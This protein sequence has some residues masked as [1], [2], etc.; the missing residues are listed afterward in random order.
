MDKVCKKFTMTRYGDDLFCLNDLV[1]NI[2]GSTNPELYMKKISKK[3]KIKDKYYVPEDR[4]MSIIRSSKSDE[5]IEAKELLEQKKDANK[6]NV[7]IFTNNK[8]SFNGKDILTL[9]INNDVW[10]K[11]GDLAEYLEY[12]DTRDA[13][14]LVHDKFKK[15]YKDIKETITKDLPNQNIPK[16]NIQD[17][18][19]FL[20][21]SGMYMLM[22]RSHKEIAVDFCI[23]V[24]EEVLPQIRKTGSYVQKNANGV[25]QDLFDNINDYMGFHCFYIICVGNGIYKLGQT[26]SITRRLREHINAYKDHYQGIIE[27]IKFEDYNDMMTIETKMKD[28]I[29][30]KN[31]KCSEKRLKELFTTTVSQCVL[32]SE[33]TFE[34][35][36]QFDLEFI[37]EKIIDYQKEL[38]VVDDIVMTDEEDDKTDVV[39]DETVNKQIN[40]FLREKHNVAKKIVHSDKDLE[41]K[42]MSHELE[43]KKIELEM[44]KLK[45]SQSN[46]SSDDE[47]NKPK[48]KSLKKYKMVEI[49]DESSESEVEVQLKKLK[50]EK[51]IDDERDELVKNNKTEQTDVTFFSAYY[52]EAGKRRC[53]GCNKFLKK[54]VFE[55]ETCKMQAKH[56]IVRLEKP[57]YEQL[58]KDMI[59]LKSKSKVAIK[60]GV[61]GPTI[62]KWIEEYEGV[63]VIAK[64]KKHKYKKRTSDSSKT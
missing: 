22:F 58:K 8:I 21:E 17:S 9:Y 1:V 40:T 23:W 3:T 30:K 13:L 12:I 63:D 28:L 37:K 43:L 39:T 14:K 50:H 52:D 34:I 20:N 48:K 51:I 19:Y 33:E 4:V 16:V 15:T 59:D 32:K 45:Y 25:Q 41:L 36:E 26:S 44:M 10:M 55:C 62:N 35:N 24:A 54:D 64:Y 7:K 47:D 46:K 11:A 38:S 60:Y 57:S 53:K 6:N 2:V 31:I 5:A 18:T 61:A 49:S 42:K 29:K 27:L 56:N